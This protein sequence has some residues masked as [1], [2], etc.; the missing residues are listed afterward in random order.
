MKV[1]EI[2]SLVEGNILGDESLEISGVTSTEFPKN[3]YLSFVNEAGQLRELEN[4]AIPCFIAPLESASESKTLIRVKNPKKAWAQILSV[5]CPPK[6]FKPGI[7]EKAFVNP[8]AELAPDVTVEPFVYI[9]ENVKIGKGSV[10][11]G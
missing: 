11:P 8:S 9:G 3:G 2:A 7:S 4:S 1:K 6:K 5:F 10:I